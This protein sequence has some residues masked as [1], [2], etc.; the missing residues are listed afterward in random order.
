MNA[1]E[2]AFNIDRE[3]QTETLEVPPYKT[4]E[5]ESLEPDKDIDHDDEYDKYEKYDE[6]TPVELGFTENERRQICGLTVRQMEKSLQHYTGIPKELSYV[7]KLMNEKSGVSIPKIFLVLRKIRHNESFQIL[8]DLFGV[9]HQHAGKI[10][11][12][13]VEKIATSLRPFIYSSQ[14]SNVT[15]SKHKDIILQCFEMFIAKPSN[16]LEEALSWS[17]C[18]QKTTV[19]YLIGCTLDG[20]IVFI[21]EGFLGSISDIKIVRQSGFL[22]FIKK[23]THEH[24][25]SGLENIKSEIFLKASPERNKA[26]KTAEEVKVN[27]S[28]VATRIP[29]IR[30]I[31]KIREFAF[32]EPNNSMLNYKR[33]F[34]I[35]HSIVIAS[36]ICNMKNK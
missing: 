26:D 6:K 17:I 16:P 31:K 25:S 9:S 14:Q 12:T 19:K 28:I 13:D 29:I 10:F 15:S 5:S 7:V 22:D 8:G 3:S 24:Y 21:S 35:E 2:K 20:L 36:A 18:K 23:D 4:P 11:L 1:T 33:S 32:L 27:K 34:L 30:A